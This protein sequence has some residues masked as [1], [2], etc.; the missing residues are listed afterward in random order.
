MMTTGVVIVWLVIN[1][2]LLAVGSAWFAER[3]ARLMESR[4]AIDRES[5][6]M[7]LTFAEDCLQHGHAH[8]DKPLSVAAHGVIARVEKAELERAQIPADFHL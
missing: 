8:N 7:L 2:F 4:N 6:M 1:F 5:V 3:H